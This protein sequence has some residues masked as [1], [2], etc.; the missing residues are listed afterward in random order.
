MPNSGDKLLLQVSDLH[1]Y[2]FTSDGVVQ[3][4]DAVSLTI[5]EGESVG[6]VGESG[7]GKS[8]TARS[9]LRLVPTPTG[10]IV[11]GA[12]WFQS[13]NMLEMSEKEIR[14]IRG[15]QISVIFQDPM[16]YLNPIMTVGDQIK[17]VVHIHLGI[18]GKELE[19]YVISILRRART[20]SPENIIDYYPHQLS[21]GMRQRVLIAMSISCSPSLLIADEPTTALDVTVQA[22]ILQLLKNIKAEMN[23][24]LLLI[25][26]DLGIVADLCDRV[27]VMY[28]GQ[29][30]EE[31]TVFNLFKQPRH[32]YT[33]GLLNSV[34]S[35]NKRLDEFPTIKGAVPQLVNP[36][37]G[38][39]FHERCEHAMT[40]CLEKD[41]VAN[42]QDDSLGYVACWLYMPTG[43]NEDEI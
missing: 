20:P 10:R 3:A 5:R 30:L 25:T 34:T 26:H 4:V 32:P 21:G 19:E 11:S 35:I 41:P 12:I 24:A 36:P 7:C 39:R 13:K 38:C 16:T 9:I 18:R 14:Q 2:L 1:T 6:L 28:A 15:E 33:Q 29:I 8:M 37:S 23:M 31:A 42:A 43:T 27:Y 17:E 40:I 22:Q